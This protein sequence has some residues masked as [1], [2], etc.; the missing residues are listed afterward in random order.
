MKFNYITIKYYYSAYCF[1]P[2]LLANV[3]KMSLE[4]FIGVYTYPNYTYVPRSI[5]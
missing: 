2:L 4:Y 3:K 1:F 5:F